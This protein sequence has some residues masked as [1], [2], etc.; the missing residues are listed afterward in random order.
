MKFA[1]GL[2]SVCRS[3]HCKSGNVDLDFIVYYRF[4][5][6]ETQLRHCVRFI[7]TRMLVGPGAPGAFQ[8]TPGAAD[9]YNMANV[10]T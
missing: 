3:Y 9:K 2:S 7:L 10:N 5:K 1:M 8:V 4:T 6:R